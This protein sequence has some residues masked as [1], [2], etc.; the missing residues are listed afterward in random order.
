MLIG[1]DWIVYE[2]GTTHTYTHAMIIIGFWNP[3]SFFLVRVAVAHFPSSNC[4]LWVVCVCVYRY[5]DIPNRL[6]DL[7]HRLPVAIGVGRSGHQRTVLWTGKIT[8][9]SSEQ[10][11]LMCARSNP[12]WIDG[13]ILVAT[14]PKEQERCGF[15]V[16]CGTIDPSIL[17]LSSSFLP[18]YELYLLFLFCPLSLVLFSLL[19]LVFFLVL[20]F[21]WLFL[22]SVSSSPISCF[23]RCSGSFLGLLFS[24]VC[25][26]SFR[27]LCSSPFSMFVSIIK[28]GVA[29]SATSR[30][31][32]WE[33]NG[34]KRRSSWQRRYL[35]SLLLWKWTARSAVPLTAS[36]TSDP[37]GFFFSIFVFLWKVK[38]FEAPREEN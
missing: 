16:L 2:D 8:T 18:W 21:R 38:A 1:F 13:W 4:L 22:W 9:P 5:T 32:W 25:G 7:Y 12:V 33:G 19:W 34:A 35:V 6:G 24:N 26:S 36:T 28:G 37:F 15:Y 29:R 27:G 23:F 30:C 20:I 31:C 14:V 11:E 10:T 3:S 17:F